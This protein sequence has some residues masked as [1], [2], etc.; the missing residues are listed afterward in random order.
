[1]DLC[2]TPNHQSIEPVH[3][4]CKR[5]VGYTKSQFDRACVFRQGTDLYG[6]PYKKPTNPPPECY[7]PDKLITI[8]DMMDTASDLG[9]NW[10]DTELDSLMMRADGNG[11][12]YLSEDEFLVFMGKKY[13]DGLPRDSYVREPWERTRRSTQIQ[14]ALYK[15]SVHFGAPNCIGD[16]PVSSF[17]YDV[18]STLEDIRKHE[19]C[20]LKY[21]LGVGISMLS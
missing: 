18:D 19:D 13:L 7:V 4:L 21:E 1:M 5:Q 14:E 11:D 9:E 8:D 16:N 3:S 10:K 12:G 20:Q 2:N 6:M 15:C 17:T